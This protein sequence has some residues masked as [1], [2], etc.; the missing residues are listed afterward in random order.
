MAACMAGC[1]ERLVRFT[2]ELAHK[3][4]EQRYELPAEQRDEMEDLLQPYQD[5]IREKML[6]EMPIETRRQLEEEQRRRE[7]E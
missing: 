3:L 2:D 6:S 1:Q 4:H 5:G 7:E